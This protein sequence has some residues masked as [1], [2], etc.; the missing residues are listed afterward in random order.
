LT[1]LAEFFIQGVSFQSP[2][3]AQNDPPRILLPKGTKTR[4]NNRDSTPRFFYCNYPVFPDSLAMSSS[5]STR[6]KIEARRRDTALYEAVSLLPNDG[7][8]GIPLAE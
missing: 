1:T 5:F 7:A 6:E 3:S 4:E 2:K 8:S